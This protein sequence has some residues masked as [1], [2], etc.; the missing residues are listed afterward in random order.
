MAKPI[1]LETNVFVA[2]QLREADFEEIA[3]MGFRSVVDNRPDGEADDQLPHHAAR[4]AAE[5]HGLAFRYAPVRNFD[6]NEDEPVEAFAAALE[7]LPGPILF[8]CR[9]GTRCTLLWAQASVGRLGLAETTRIAAAAGFD[10][11]PIRDTLEERLGLLA[12]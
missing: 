12:A 5:Q 6:I 7:E 10:L 8:Y 4:R 9:S 3:A 1:Q 2:P 11:A